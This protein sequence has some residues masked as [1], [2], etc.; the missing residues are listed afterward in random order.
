MK[1][2]CSHCQKIWNHP[3]NRCIFCGGEIDYIH[4]TKYRVIGSTEVFIPSTSNEKVPYFVILL[5]DMN[6]Q[7]IVKKSFVNYEIGELID[8]LE[9]NHPELTIGII[10]S[11]L[12]GTQIAAYIIQYGYQTILKTR[13]EESKEKVFAKI[14]KQITKRLGNE[15]VKKALICLKITTDYND[16]ALCDI[17]IEASVENLDI[18]KS[19]YKSLSSVC[20]QSTILATNSSS[21][22]I[23]DLASVTGMPE[24]CIGMHF[25]NPVHRMDLVEIVI[26]THTSLETQDIIIDFVKKINKIPI[27]VKNSPGYVVNRLLLPQIN[28]AILVFEEGVATKEDIDKAVKLGLNHPMGPFELADLI[29]LDVCLSILD[30][31]YVEL[32][33][34]KYKPASLLR[35]LVSEG[36]I[37]IK[38]GEGFY[39]YK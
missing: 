5:E 11:G 14:K 30:V 3:I 1:Y 18:K 27:V 37:G 6:G 20:G 24:K 8:F 15:E 38:S 12:L 32:N 19:I 29:G 23:D 4:E 16:L 33:D 25:F 13:T 17:V 21:L 31:L 22:S 7:K 9:E 34:I 28:E 26:G 39:K 2:H 10:G 35:N 36:K